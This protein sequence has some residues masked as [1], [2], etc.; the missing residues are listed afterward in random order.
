MVIVGIRVFTWKTE[1]LLPPWFTTAINTPP[2]R[3][4]EKATPRG[5]D[6]TA[7]AGAV[8]NT[9]VEVLTVYMSMALPPLLTTAANKLPAIS[10]E[11]AVELGPD[12]VVKG[13]PDTWL[14]TPVDVLTEYTETFVLVLFPTAANKLPFTMGEK[15]T[16][17]GF[18]PAAKG[19]PA[20]GVKTPVDVLTEYTETE[21][22][23]SPLF[24]TAANRLPFTTGEKATAVGPDPVVNGDPATAVNAPV[25]IFTV[26]TE[27][28]VLPLLVT[29]ANRLPF[30]RGEKAT[31]H[32][33]VPAVKGEPE[34]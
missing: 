32:G 26:Y 30:T 21:L 17:F 15:D 25:A 14:K 2:E 5:F 4:G 29:A 12:P 22:A 31:P 33:L 3:V 13:D 11:K 24:A 8:V 18:D 1:T 23:L 10:C 6:T 27:T 9:P 19:D 28:E 7:E 20:T 16:P 34:I